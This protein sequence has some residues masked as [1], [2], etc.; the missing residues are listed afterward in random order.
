M[1]PHAGSFSLETVSA[2]PSPSGLMAVVLV[3]LDGGYAHSLNRRRRRPS[4][5]A[6]GSNEV[7]GSQQVLGGSAGHG[8]RDEHPAGSSCPGAAASSSPLCIKV[9]AWTS[10]SRRVRAPMSTAAVCQ[11]FPH[12]EPPDPG[13]T[14][15]G[16]PVRVRIRRRIEESSPIGLGTWSDRRSREPRRCLQNLFLL[17]SCAG[18]Y[19]P[20]PTTGS[21]TKIASRPVLMQPAG[22]ARTG[23]LG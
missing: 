11:S 14:C 3:R 15:D 18:T 21:A 8:V 16:I 6:V 5:V 9:T 4:E 12:S 10:A 7:L 22:V 23:P 13:A 2:F 17:T 1:V 19:L 20:T